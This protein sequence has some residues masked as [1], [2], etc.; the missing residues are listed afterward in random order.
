MTRGVKRPSSKV[1]LGSS[2]ENAL[3]GRKREEKVIKGQIRSPNISEKVSKELEG[4]ILVVSKGGRETSFG[5]WKKEEEKSAEGDSACFQNRFQKEKSSI[6]SLYS[7][8]I[9]GKKG[10]KVGSNR[11]TESVRVPAEGE[12]SIKNQRE[13]IRNRWELVQGTS[14]QREDG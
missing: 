11:S 3:R 7:E 2:R 1:T 13:N 10:V 12:C 8:N 4:G 5:I 6:K 14:Q 9:F